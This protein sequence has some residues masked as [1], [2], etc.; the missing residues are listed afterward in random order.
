MDDRRQGKKMTE[1][2]LGRVGL[3]SFCVP[4]M[5]VSLNQRRRGGYLTATIQIPSWLPSWRDY[6][7]RPQPRESPLWRKQNKVS[8][9]CF[10]KLWFPCMPKRALAFLNEIPAISHR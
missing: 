4:S 5:V 1:G 10:I 7:K 9:I 8:I 2:S 3:R 6:T